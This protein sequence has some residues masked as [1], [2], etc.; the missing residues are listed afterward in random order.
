VD[1]EV[2]LYPDQ[3]ES[4]VSRVAHYYLLRSSAYICIRAG[5]RHLLLMQMAQTVFLTQFAQAFI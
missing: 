2:F 5:A 4:E 3:K 1:G